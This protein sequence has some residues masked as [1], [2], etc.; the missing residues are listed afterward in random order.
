[1][2]RQPIRPPRPRQLTQRPSQPELQ[3]RVLASR[4]YR[5]QTIPTPLPLLH[6]RLLIRLQRQTMRLLSLRAMCP[7]CPQLPTPSLRVLT[8][9]RCPPHR[10]RLKWLQQARLLLEPRIRAP[11]RHQPAVQQLRRLRHPPRPSPRRLTKPTPSKSPPA[12][13]RRAS[14]SLSPGNRLF[15]PC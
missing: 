9:C 4:S 12:R 7:F 8:P 13:K 3:V 6:L 1:M 15:T 5:R 2:R 14:R 10:P 11:Q